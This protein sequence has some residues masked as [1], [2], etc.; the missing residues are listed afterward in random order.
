MIAVNCAAIPSNLIESERFGYER[1]A[2]TGAIARRPGRIEQA[3][4]GTLFLDEIGASPATT[5]VCASR[6]PAMPRF[7]STGT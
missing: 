6:H 1:G 7:P 5:A 3:D 2:L 4:G